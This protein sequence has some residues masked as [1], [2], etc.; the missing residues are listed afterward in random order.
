[1]AIVVVGAGVTGLTVAE[2]LVQAGKEVIVLE[3]EEVMG[4]LCRSYRYGDFTFDVGPHRLFSP[5]NAIRDYFLSILGENYSFTSRD[6]MVYMN[7][8]YLTWPLSFGAVF[9]LPPSDMFRCVRDLLFTRNLE[10]IFS[11]FI[12]HQNCNS[13]FC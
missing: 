1:M 2:R 5:D 3:R 10:N 4:G 13:F 9:S 6:S 8:K 11:L 7:G 12:F